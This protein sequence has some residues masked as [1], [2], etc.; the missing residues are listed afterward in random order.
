MCSLRV[1]VGDI[2]KVRDVDVI[3]NAANGIG[4]LGAGVAGALAASGGDAL[5]QAARDYCKEH[6]PI[7]AGLCYNTDA[8]LL[9]R[10]GVKEIY[11]AV[12][13]EFP[14]QTSSIEVITSA[15]RAVLTMAVINGVQSIAIPGLGTGIGGIDKTT[16][17]QR[18]AVIIEP[19]RGQLNII[20]A[21]RN[22]EFITA[23]KKALKIESE[24]WENT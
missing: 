12:T 18:M 5:R 10:R 4:V 14:G 15:L 20:V 9:K 19:Y 17:A 3:V 23:F 16:A 11:H 1:G 7:K 2:T 22:Q 6:G 21:D 13:M 8:G 24:S